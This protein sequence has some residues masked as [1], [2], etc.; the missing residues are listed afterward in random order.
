MRPELQDIVDEVSRLLG[1]PATLE[2]RDLNLVAFCSHGSE[3][4][5]IRRRSILERRS[6]ADVRRWFGRFGIATADGAVRI[7]AAPAEGVLARL[8]LPARWKGLTHGYLWLL[9][10]E[11]GVDDDAVPAALALAERAGALMAQQSRTREQLEF[12]VRDLLSPDRE[13]VERAATELDDQGLVRRGVAVTAVELRLPGRA[14]LEPVN[15]WT[16][17]RSVLAWSG[18]HHTTLLVPAPASAHDI[19]RRALDLPGQRTGL[20]AGIGAPRPDL[21]EAGASWREARLA[22]R[23]AE[24]VPALRPVAAWAEL[25]VY[26]LLACGPEDALTSAVLDPAVR[27]LLEHGDPG[28]AGTALT[29]L[30]QA[31]NVAATAAALSVHRQTVYYRLR[32]VER[33]TGLDLSRGD[34]R[35]LLHLGLSMAPLLTPPPDAQRT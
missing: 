6:S 18:R 31:G 22:A 5:E 12:A 27:R 7:P 28:L 33:V 35:L 24:S 29:F 8:C 9:D 13:A 10:E 1:R 16:L 17:P 34:H 32:Q 11:P 21:T 14:A 20:L 25:G 15:L 19:A 30:D 3:I 4:D 23:V 26:R 2:D